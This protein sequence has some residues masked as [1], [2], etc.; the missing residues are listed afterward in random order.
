M[1]RVCWDVTNG[2]NLGCTCPPGTGCNKASLDATSSFADKAYCTVGS[3]VAQNPCLQLQS[4]YTPSI[5]ARTSTPIGRL[6]STRMQFP[7]LTSHGL[8]TTV[9]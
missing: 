4:P 8:T 5:P 9:Q 1:V 6:T 2:G 7:A 3:L